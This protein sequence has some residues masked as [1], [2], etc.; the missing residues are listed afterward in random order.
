M[1]PTLP[2]CKGCKDAV[3]PDGCPAPQRRSDVERNAA[4]TAKHAKM[5]WA[6]DLPSL[7]PQRERARGVVTSQRERGAAG[8]RFR[9][10]FPASK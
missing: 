5:L 9:N 6:S 2:P 10:A 3:E 1:Q 8:F 4:K 7:L